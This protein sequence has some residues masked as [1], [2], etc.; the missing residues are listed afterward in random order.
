[1]RA[2]LIATGE[3]MS[4]F[5]DEFATPMLPM[6]DRPLLQHA[7]E[8]LASHG[9]DRFDVVL[10]RRARAI[11]SL[12]GDGTRWG[13]S[14]RYRTAADVARPWQALGGFGPSA[15]DEP[16]LLAHADRLPLVDPSADRPRDGSPVVY[17]RADDSEGRP[18]WSGWAWVLPDDLLDLPPDADVNDLFDRLLEP[19]RGPRVVAVGS[20][21][22]ATTGEALMRSH[23][24]LI[25]SR[26][27]GLM[28]SGREVR[29]EVWVSSNV[30]LHP[31]VRLVPPVF[32]AEDCRLGPGVRLG[33]DA[34]VGAGSV[35][36]A[37][38]TVAE[39]VLFPDTY[40][41][42]SLD[43]NEA[44]VSHGRLAHLR[45]GPDL[46]VDDEQLISSV[47]AYRLGDSLR[48]LL[49]RLAA[50]AVLVATAP[51]LLATSLLI[52]IAR[53]GPALIDREV[54]RLPAPPD[55]DRWRVYRLHRFN[56]PLD[57]SPNWADLLFRVLP[58]L[59]DV[60]LGNLRIVGVA[61][62]GRDEVAAMSEDRR[63]L[64][65]NARGGLI[66]V[67][68]DSTD[69]EPADHAAWSLRRD[70]GLVGVY[71]AWSLFGRD[72]RARGRADGPTHRPS[73]AA[74][75]RRKDRAATPRSVPSGSQRP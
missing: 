50:S 28:L 4:P 62:R 74:I 44:L 3:T 75:D 64:Y 13:V 71:L 36:D 32:V 48:A 35:I 66:D 22:D 52:R 38:S 59:I 20:I 60:A 68:P 10:G 17:V 9:I 40:V 42:A 5:S 16:I 53:G 37:D 27:A 7:V 70:L 24:D 33:P 21:L 26:P 19:G 46:I 56:V 69:D 67:W 47:A 54:V 58:G 34:F 43:L 72:R 45:L 23:R 57:G 12:L 73:I 49:A 65:R 41:G 39:S 11:Q 51:L 31:S 6:I 61:P 15:D 8:W 25:A 29:P 1:M 18:A 55:P 14:I 63:A 2:I 30:R